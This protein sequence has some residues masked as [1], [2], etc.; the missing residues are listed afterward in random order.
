RPGGLPYSPGFF[1]YKG[2]YIEANGMFE[3]QE[4]GPAS[5]WHNLEYEIIDNNSLGN[6]SAL[7]LGS[8]SDNPEWQV[9]D[10]LTSSTHSLDYLDVNDYQF[11]KV[12]FN[13]ADSS[14]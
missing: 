13:F 1:K 4:I 2:T 3:S 5:K 14:S 11:I 9:L 12:R 7:L 8:H 10:T 6:Y